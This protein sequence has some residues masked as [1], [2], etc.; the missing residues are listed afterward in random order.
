YNKTRLAPEAKPILKVGVKGA[1]QVVGW[2]YERPDSKKGRSF[3]LT[4]G[5]F[6]DNFGIDEFRRVIANGILWTAH[7]EIPASGAPVRVS[8]QDLD[9]GPPPDQK[10]GK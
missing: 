4:L 5:H 10:T 6:H 9:V 3:G 2:V 1:D 8:A 7:V